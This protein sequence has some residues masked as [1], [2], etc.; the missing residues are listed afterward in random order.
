MTRD[1]DKWWFAAV[2]AP[3]D[4]EMVESLQKWAYES[5][6]EPI[7]YER[8]DPHLTVHPG[9]ECDRETALELLDAA[10]SLTGRR[11]R[12]S[13]LDFYPDERRPYFP[14]LR[15]EEGPV[16]GVRGEMKEVMRERGAAAFRQ[17]TPPHITLVQTDP[18]EK[19]GEPVFVKRE[20]DVHDVAD[21]LGHRQGDIGGWDVVFSTVFA[22]GASIR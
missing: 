6:G 13:G 21:A 15:L 3:A 4:Y 9:V 5:A 12:V 10:D 14:L 19:D 1:T 22:R 2:P 18:E 16:W 7:S 11:L 20:K 8:P 17:P